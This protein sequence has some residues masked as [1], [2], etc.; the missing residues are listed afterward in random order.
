MKTRKCSIIDTNGRMG[1]EFSWSFPAP[2]AGACRR[3]KQPPILARMPSSSS[4]WAIQGS[5]LVTAV[6]VGH[7]AGEFF[8]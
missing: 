2:N 3:M 8:A 1:I 7:G 4:M 5:R 6:Q